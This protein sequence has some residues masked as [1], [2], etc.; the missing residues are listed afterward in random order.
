VACTRMNMAPRLMATI[1]MVVKIEANTILTELGFGWEATVNKDNAT[2]G[3]RV[4]RDQARTTQVGNSWTR[5]P[6][7]LAQSGPVVS[8]ENRIGRV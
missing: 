3:K 1:R 8:Y 7:R 4:A 2:D 6:S 5:T